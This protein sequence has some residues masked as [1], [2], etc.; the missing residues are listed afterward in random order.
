M[1]TS[2]REFLEY[3]P[4]LAAGSMIANQ[5]GALAQTAPKAPGTDPLGVRAD[6]PVT[7]NQIFL[8]SAYIAPSPIQAVE[9]AS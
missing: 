9:A 1:S 6:F 4:V 2:R 7:R 5:S 3:L 8:Y